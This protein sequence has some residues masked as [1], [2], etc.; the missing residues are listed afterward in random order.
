[1]SSNDHITDTIDTI[2]DS[3]EIVDEYEVISKRES[4]QAHVEML[5]RFLKNKYGA[6][7]DI[8]QLLRNSSK[9]HIL[10]GFQ[11]YILSTYTL[12]TY[13]LKFYGLYQQNDVLVLIFELLLKLWK[14]G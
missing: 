3:F 11:Y 8:H 14:S 5:D 7:Y 13:G 6:G 1:M 10:S 4:L 12:A 9:T 2:E